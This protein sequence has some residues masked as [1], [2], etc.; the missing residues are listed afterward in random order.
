MKKMLPKLN[1]TLPRYLFFELDVSEFELRS[2]EVFKRCVENIVSPMSVMTGWTS[3]GC[4]N[5]STLSTSPICF[6]G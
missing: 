1:L 2:K 3:S 6:A 5:L 4:D